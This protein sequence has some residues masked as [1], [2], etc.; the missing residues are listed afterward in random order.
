[1]SN[2]LNICSSL[3]TNSVYENPKLPIQKLTKLDHKP[4]FNVIESELNLPKDTQLVFDNLRTRNSIS[5]CWLDSAR[6][7]DNSCSYLSNPSI[8][9]TYSITSNEI[10]ITT[11][12]S[13]KSFKLTNNSNF[14][15]WLDE[16]QSVLQSLFTK[17]S[18]YGFS[19]G[20]ISVLGYELSKHSL[21]GYKFC[22]TKLEKSFDR[23]NNNDTNKPDAILLFCHD[24]LVYEHTNEV[25]KRRQIN[26]LR[27]ISDEETN[28]L[29]NDN[30]NCGK[31]LINLIKNLNTSNEKLNIEPIEDKSKSRSNLILKFKPKVNSDDYIKAIEEAR[32]QI[33][34]GESYELCLTTKFYNDNQKLSDDDCYEI[35]KHLRISNPAPYASFISVKNINTN[36]LSSSPERFM[37]VDNDQ[38]IEMKPIKGTIKRNLNDI[39][40]D[41]KLMNELKYNEKERA[42]NLMIVDL[43]RAD[44]LKVC[45]T[46]S[47]ICP[48]LMDIESFESVHQLVSTISGKKLENV[49]VIESIKACFPPGSMTGSPKLRSVKIL[50]IL[51]NFELRRFYSGCI[52][53]ID[54]KGSI[55][56]SVVIRT[57]IYENES[58]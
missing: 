32:N 58:K 14:W 35:Y 7:L 30:N 21:N 27:T 49:G 33:K 28:K 25:W 18:L 46:N 34:L 51:E 36:V 24:V 22:E 42:E 8:S 50:E 40:D 12:D 57:L 9:L 16:F 10:N 6:V 52:G 4:S 23:I 37:K 53:Y 48:K 41:I 5:N 17:N 47:V 2:F 55:D 26:K 44:L 1:M 45:H 11:L 29:F 13:S 38:M 54:V 15:D 39:D 3:S 20:W 43:I 19:I 31:Y 56:L